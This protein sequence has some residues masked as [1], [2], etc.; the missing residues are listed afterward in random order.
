[1]PV[2]DDTETTSGPGTP[3]GQAALMDGSL[4]T[5]VKRWCKNGAA[6]LQLVPQDKL[7]RETGHDLNDTGLKITH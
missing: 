1:M 7:R 3:A 4:R 2:S 5:Q 6:A